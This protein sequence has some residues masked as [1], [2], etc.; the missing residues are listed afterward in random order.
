MNLSLGNPGKKREEKNSV[1]HVTVY[2]T[3]Y[4]FHFDRIVCTA[5]S[6]SAASLFAYGK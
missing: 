3:D 1:S 4:I 5:D 6:L 2:T